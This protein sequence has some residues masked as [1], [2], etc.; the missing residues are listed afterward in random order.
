M[1]LILLALAASLLTVVLMVQARGEPGDADMP[2]ARASTPASVVERPAS[3]TEKS[4]WNTRRKM[5][6]VRQEN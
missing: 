5:H 4:I 1:K 6:A 2:A 3:R